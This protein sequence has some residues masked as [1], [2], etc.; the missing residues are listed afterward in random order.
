VNCRKAARET[1]LGCAAAKMISIYLPQGGKRRQKPFFLR[2]K[3]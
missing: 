2:A 1:T 3:S